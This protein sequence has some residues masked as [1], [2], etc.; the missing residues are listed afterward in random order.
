M[1]LTKYGH[2]CFSIEIN[3]IKIL[4]DPGAFTDKAAVFENIEIILISHNHADH[5][6]INLLRTIL[7]NNAPIILTNEAVSEQLLQ[8]GIDSQVIAPND[9]NNLMGIKIEAFGEDHIEVYPGISA[10]SNIAFMI[11][12]TFFYPGDSYLVPDKKIKVLAMPVAGPWVKLSE[13]IDYSLKLKPEIAFPVHDGMLTNPGLIA[14]L[15]TKI[16]SEKNIQFLTLELNN[17]VEI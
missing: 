2:N 7:G 14:P 13:A 11:N 1:I 10:G 3:T 9:I 12:D 15:T 16:L 6:D 17:P 4:F 5:L 8:E